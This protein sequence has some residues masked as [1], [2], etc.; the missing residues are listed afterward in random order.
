[1]LLVCYFSYKYT[2]ILPLVGLQMIYKKKSNFY[3]CLYV[4]H[5]FPKSEYSSCKVQR[6]VRPFPQ[7]VFRNIITIHEKQEKNLSGGP[8]M[9]LQAWWLK[10]IK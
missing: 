5:I 9:D 10:K 8:K 4:L 3:F 1:M 6:H 7:M 2:L